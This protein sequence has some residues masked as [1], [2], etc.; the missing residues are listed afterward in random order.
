M[1]NWESENVENVKKARANC[2]RLQITI[3][4]IKNKL[5]E[6]RGLALIE[7][8]ITLHELES[9]LRS[10]SK[11]LPEDERKELLK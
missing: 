8:Q 2:R 9:S 7:D 10:W 1:D 3:N 4:T 5:H 6:R 11:A